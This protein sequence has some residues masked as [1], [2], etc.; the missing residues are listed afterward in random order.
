M[1]L[2]R[3]FKIFLLVTTLS[4]FLISTLTPAFASHD[5]TQGAQQSQNTIEPIPTP[6]PDAPQIQPI[7][8]PTA[9]PKIRQALGWEDLNPISWPGAVYDFL[10]GAT[11]KAVKGAFYA[12]QDAGFEQINN[13][14]GAELV[15]SQR[16]NNNDPEDTCIEKKINRA[17]MG[18]SNLSEVP[19]PGLL[20]YLGYV[21]SQSLTLPVPI[22]STQYFASINPFKE[23][24][25]AAGAEELANNN[26]LLSIWRTSRNIAFALSAAVLMVVGFMIMFRWKLDPRTTVTIQNSLPRVVVALILIT[27][28]FA[29][30]GLMI[31]FTRLITEVVTSLVAVPGEAL[32]GLSAIGL[33]V[34]AGGSLSLATGGLFALFILLLGL[35]LSIMILIVFIVLIFKLLMRYITFL[36]LTIF[37]P[38]FFL[39]GALPGGEGIIFN[40]FKRQTAALLAVPFTALFV[41]LSFAIGFS[42]FTGQGDLNFPS[43]W[44]VVGGF[45]NTAVGF[46]VLGPLIGIGLFFFATKV[47]DIV[48]EVFGIKE[49]GARKG[50]GPG[51][52]VGAPIGGLQAAGNISRGVEGVQRGVKVGKDVAGNLSRR[53][54]GPEQTQTEGGNVSISNQPTPGPAARTARQ[55]ARTILRPFAPK[56]MSGRKPWQNISMSEADFA[57]RQRRIQ[58]QI[59]AAAARG[60]RGGG[61]PPTEDQDERGPLETP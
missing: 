31:D 10:R 60:R 29:I 42:G 57:E 4:L 9:D 8:K 35:I 5:K 38:F 37:A 58:E 15:D 49:L 54:W 19:N 46:A 6:N 22:N 16:L 2:P 1:C 47:P 53:G 13:C 26:I 32:L 34:L 21:G 24:R 55:L 7:P 12:S 45:A 59:K 3:K 50:I 41:N 25:A 56:D 40:W 33:L 17:A 61:P 27:F 39:A 20:D 23:A 48:D 52:I 18:V 28:S 44:P 43:P 51:I 14:S 36:I 30:A 11:A